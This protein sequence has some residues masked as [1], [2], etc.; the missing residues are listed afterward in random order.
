MIWLFSPF[1]KGKEEPKMQIASPEM[2][3]RK[4]SEHIF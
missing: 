1:F 2:G 4:Y 3:S